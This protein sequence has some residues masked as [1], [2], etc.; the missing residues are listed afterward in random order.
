M[1]SI[2]LRQAQRPPF[3]HR[4]LIITT[5]RIFVV[6]FAPSTYSLTT[7]TYQPT[8]NSQHLKRMLHIR[9]SNLA[10]AVPPNFLMRL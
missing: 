7:L 2:P 5:F 3:E 10:F 9:K 1:V 4:G 6:I 8:P